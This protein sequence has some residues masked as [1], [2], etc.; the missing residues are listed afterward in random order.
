MSSFRNRSITTENGTA[1]IRYVPV[2][3][4]FNF[5][6]P[7]Y[8]AIGT[9]GGGKTTLCLD[10]LYQKAAEATNIYYFTQTEEKLGAQD[11]GLSIIPKAC[12]RRPTY[13]NISA[14]YNEILQ[15]NES[16]DSNPAKLSQLLI[17]ITN[18]KVLTARIMKT[19]NDE[20][21]IVGRERLEYYKDVYKMDQKLASTYACSDKD[22]F[23]Y[24][25]LSRI[26]LDFASTSN[27]IQT[28]SQENMSRLQSLYSRRPKTILIMDDVTSALNNLSNDRTKVRFGSSSVTKHQAT[29]SILKDLMTRGRHMNAIICIFLHSLNILGDAKENI[30]NLIIIEPSALSQ[31]NTLKK[32]NRTVINAL[33]TAS[34]L[35]FTEE[36]KYHIM[37]MNASSGGENVTVNVTKADL[38]DNLTKIE[39]D[40]LNEKF[41]SV[42]NK[43]TEGIITN[44]EALNANAETDNGGSES[45]ENA[46]DEGSGEY[47]YSDIAGDD[48]IASI[49]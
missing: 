6:E 12:V 33:N 27:N 41:I 19:I 28:L 43:I 14:V 24:E 36:F 11:G 44:D 47:E 8:V 21:E 9:T 29:L 38:H 15:I 34:P 16:I 10:I 32:F 45:D 39:L 49:V 22:G 13:E 18:D 3:D 35:V 2:K 5:G 4:L 17:A 7:P 42:Y 20:A 25:T 46:D 23:V 1:Q 30:L 40:P 48:V 26:I 37:H 31:L